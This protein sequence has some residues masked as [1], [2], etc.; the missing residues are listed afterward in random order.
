MRSSAV[1]F[2]FVL[3]ILAAAITLACG[4][5]SS[6][7][8]TAVLESISIN[9]Q[10]A[11]AEKF[12][13]GE[14]QFVATGYYSAPPSPITPLNARAGWGVCFQ[15]APTTAVSVSSNGLAHCA[16]DAS[17]T[18]SVFASDFPNPS[19]ACNVIG[20]CGGGCVVSGYAQLTCP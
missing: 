1:L 5:S 10:S 3:L 15:N 9:P 8:T 7:N 18:Y 16:A 4:S 17:G 6:G 2:V 13:N 19:L 12:P 14:V 20:A 11:D